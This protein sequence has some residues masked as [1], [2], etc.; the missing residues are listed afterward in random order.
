MVEE[1]TECRS[2]A[3]KFDYYPDPEAALG[4]PPQVFVA[5]YPQ[6]YSGFSKDG[7]P[8]F[9]SKP[10]QMDIDGVQ[11][12]TTL[13]GI[14]KYHWHIMQHDYR[15]RLLDFKKSNP[16]FKRFECVSV[17]DL[18]QL[19]IT[20]V[21]SRTLDIIKVQANIDSLCFPETMNKMV[22]VNAPRFF[23]ATWSI[24]KGFVDARTAAKIELFSSTKA[25]EKCLREL[26]E[27]NE[28]P[29]DYGGTAESTDVTMSKM[30][31]SNVTTKVLY[32]R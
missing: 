6:L 23:S 10:G 5:Q 26:I 20:K 19:T 27:M 7:C 25:A 1:A 31:A 17:L 24:I 4:C 15:N 9:Y 28:L 22:I 2:D 18:S 21:G 12:I 11:C 13:E 32:V 16:S 8:V 14:L 30:S 3:R 29:S